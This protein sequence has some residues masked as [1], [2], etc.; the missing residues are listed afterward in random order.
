MKPTRAVRKYGQS[1][2]LDYI[3]RSLITSGELGRLVKEDGVSGVTSNPTIFEK[4]IAGSS[5]YDEFLGG[6]LKKD[7]H[8]DV[9][10]LYEKL[11]IE[12][13]Q[14]TADILRQ[15]YEDN[16]C[17]DGF[18]S[19]EL[20]PKLAHDIKG[21]IAEARR[22]WKAINRPNIMLKVPAT[23]EGI[24]VIETLI[25]EGMNINVTL[26]FSKSQYEAV[27]EAYIQGLE[28]CPNPSKVASVASFFVSRVD[29]IA[30]KA[31]E[32]VGTPEALTLK[33]RIAIANSKMS[34]KRFTEIFSG[35]RWEKLVNKGARV[36]RVL[37]ASTSTKNPSYSDVLYVEELVGQDTVNTLPPVTLNAFRDHGKV[38]ASLQEG[39]R[40]AREVLEHLASIGIDLDAIT[41]RL[42]KEG[43]AAFAN[44]F[45]N[46]LAALEEKRKIILGGQVDR[47]LTSLGMYQSY[48]DTRL[49]SWKN[50]GLSRRLWAK[51][52]TLWFLKPVPEITDRLGWLVLPENMHDQIED[53]ISFAEKIKDEGTLHVVLLGMGGSS[54]SPEV[55]QHIFVN[56]PG[57]PELLVLDSTHPDAIR[58]VE[59]E[60]DLRNTIFLVSSKSGTTLETLSLFQYFWKKI[61][62]SDDNPGR[63]FV[64]ITDPGTPLMQLAQER[65]FQRIFPAPP[66]VGGRYSALSVF[67]LVPAALIGMDIHRL[68]D[69]AW[70]ASEHSAFCVP[71]HENSGLLLGAAL[72]ELAVNG[73]DKVTFLTSPSLRSLPNW[74]EQLIAEST[75]KD[76]KGIIPIIDEPL[77]PSDKYSAD[78]LF[79]YLSLNGNDEAEIYERMRE[80]KAKGHP[81]VRIYLP[82]KVN[83]GEEIF[84]W[85]VAV[86]TAGSVLGIN[87][88][89]QSDVQLSKDLAREL[90][91]KGGVSGI[92]L[93]ESVETV[94]IGETE[95]LASA[96]REWLALA[97]EGDYVGIQAYLAPKRETTEAFQKIRQ[98]L[99]IRLRLATTMGYGP[100]FLHSTGQLH[101]G[102]PNKGL[103]LQLVDEPVEDIEV[104]ETDY[105]FGA[106]I[107]AQAIGDYQAL[108]RYGRR[109][110]RINLNRD[111]ANGLTKLADLLNCQ[112]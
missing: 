54:L 9:H 70:N 1:I 100:R 86:A 15:V 51:D 38:R 58:A 62:E 75:G 36:Q 2:W 23:S 93:S 97:H 65:G 13:I 33:G 91:E 34:Y 7:P 110:L 8:M 61:G 94:P 60:I 10:T 106:L 84:R 82:D 28:K 19:L 14:A 90:M 57:F 68:L 35:N 102:G 103:F 78:R 64:A 20:S 101:K 3:R 87:P 4:A 17:T 88:F 41:E 26:I 44:S 80:L 67:G 11:V 92:Q 48:V 111:V 63:K 59:S 37:W 16:D 47:L 69:R 53:L 43:V 77:I 104:P 89:D 29:R 99:L 83:I 73:R 27:A 5:D 12:D 95:A 96:I 85:E 18:V 50:T 71:E 81:T 40:E 25:A 30:D 109:V 45:D 52:S 42:L 107:E 55:F 72:G 24:P 49:K 6:L 108:K 74:L 105:T 56:T 112:D 79:V 39:E 46:L 22:L 21:S 98:E 31:L 66:D 32:E 76:G